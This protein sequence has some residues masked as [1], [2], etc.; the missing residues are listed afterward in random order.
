MLPLLLL[1]SLASLS[2]AI[3]LQPRSVKWAPC[4]DIKL[5]TT[6]TYDCGT[7][8]VPLDYGPTPKRTVNTTGTIDLQFVRIPAA[9][10]PSKGSVFFNFGGPG[11]P[12]RNTL[13]GS[14]AK[15]L[16]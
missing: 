2:V 4:R 10:Q 11:F 1:S 6:W 16:A 12:A 3:P 9:E 15:F 14:G 13:V 8:N 7:L 5:N